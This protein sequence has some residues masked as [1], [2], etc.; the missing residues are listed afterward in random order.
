MR[1]HYLAL[2]ASAWLTG[3]VSLAPFEKAAAETL[4]DARKEFKTVLIRQEGGKQPVPT[5]PASLFR[6]IRYDAAGGKYV[7]YLSPDPK[8][9]KKHPAIIWI[10]GGDC[11][12]ID[13]V[14]NGA[15]RSN[16]QTAAQYRK[17]GIVMMFPSL[18]GGNG[19]PGAR[20]GFFGE[21]EDVLAAADY[22]RKQPYADPDR[23]YLGGH[24]TGG[25]LALL[26]AAY[27]NKFRAVFAFGPVANVASYGSSFLPFDYSNKREL[28]LRAPILW[29][30]SIDVPVFVI[31]GSAS[32]NAGSLQAMS[33]RRPANPKLSFI[34][35]NGGDHFNVLAPVNELIAEKI[36]RDTGQG[37]LAL[38][39][40]EV[41]QR[42]AQ[43]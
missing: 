39:A 28:E 26:T 11:N 33:A 1:R 35:V 9:G 27:P 14:W 8:D 37:S 32:P 36:I 7:A 10:T 4:L 20:E 13:E 24:S 16:D 21:V 15:P 17:A 18:R 19:N 42:F 29:L 34:A 22:L 2:I 25:T 30:S 40:G 12:S 3:T 41:N 5:A 6:T 43:R 23:I 31:E 38:Q